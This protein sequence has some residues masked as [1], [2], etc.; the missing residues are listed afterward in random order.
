MVKKKKAKKTLKV[1]KVKKVKKTVKRKKAVRAVKGKKIIKVKEKV[2]GKVDHFFGHISVAAIKISSPI[3]VGDIVH[4]KGHTTDF[5]QRIDSMQIEHL[6]VDQA[7]KG[8]DIGIKVKDKVRDHDVLYLASKENVSRLTASPSLPT[9]S[10]RP[11]AAPKQ[12]AKSEPYSQTKF[13]SF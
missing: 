2:L 1:K 11:A 7:K 9:L 6:S 5:V 13:F 8:D 12:Q 10:P 4:I 3:K